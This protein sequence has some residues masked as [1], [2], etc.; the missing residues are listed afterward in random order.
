MSVV[1]RR[2]PVGSTRA[3]VAP[4]PSESASSSPS[5]PPLGLAAT[6]VITILG[7][8][9]PALAAG[10][11]IPSRSLEIRWARDAVLA[12]D[13]GE[14]RRSGSGAVP[15]LACVHA[16]V[17]DQLTASGS[18]EAPRSLAPSS[19]RVS[20]SPRYPPGASDGPAAA[21]IG[22]R[23][24]LL[25]TA[26]APYAAKLLRQDVTPTG[27]AALRA[28]HGH[29]RRAVGVASVATPRDAHPRGA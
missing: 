5:Q 26:A 14:G 20:G 15:P 12:L 1:A 8:M 4:T 13:A 25:G 3:A 7:S 27:A 9:T 18:V 28:N 6:S 19:G 29:G 2:A 17:H 10:P 24:S 23:P 22:A 11:Y 16:S 21:S